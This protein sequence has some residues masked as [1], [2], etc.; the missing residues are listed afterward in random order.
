MSES[1]PCRYVVVTECAED[2][3]EDVSYLARRTPDGPARLSAPELDDVV[4]MLCHVSKLGRNEDHDRRPRPPANEPTVLVDALEE[5]PGQDTKCMSRRLRVKS[6]SQRAD[7]EAGARQVV[8]APTSEG[9][10]LIARRQ[11]G[12]ESEA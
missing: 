6:A 2:P 7:L 5:R 10:E 9:D 11:Q 8:K 3:R 4:R 1:P 12:K